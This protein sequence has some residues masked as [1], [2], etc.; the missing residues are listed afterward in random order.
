MVNAS[1]LYKTVTFVGDFVG[2]FSLLSTVLGTEKTL[3]CQNHER[4]VVCFA[5]LMSVFF[6]VWF[7]CLFLAAIFPVSCFMLPLPEFKRV[8]LECVETNMGSHNFFLMCTVW[9]S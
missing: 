9:F 5:M 7:Y 3:N 4:S 6:S 8:F 2:G 1:L